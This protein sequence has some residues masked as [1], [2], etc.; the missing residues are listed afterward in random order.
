MTGTSLIGRLNMTVNDVF[1]CKNDHDPVALVGE[2]TCPV[3]HEPMQVIG[4]LEE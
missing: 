4:W 2:D 3:C 1:Y